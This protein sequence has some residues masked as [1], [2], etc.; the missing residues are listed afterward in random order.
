MTKRHLEEE[1]SEAV[2]AHGHPGQERRAARQG[3]GV[4]GE[5]GKD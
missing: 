5:D 2:D 4:R 1:L 3:L